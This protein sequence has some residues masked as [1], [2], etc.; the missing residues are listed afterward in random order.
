MADKPM[1]WVILLCLVALGGVAIPGPVRWCFVPACVVIAC[2]AAWDWRRTQREAGRIRQKLEAE[3]ANG[4][5]LRSRLEASESRFRTVLEFAP[6]A[7]LQ[8]DTD[9][10]IVY[11]NK[12][13]EELVG[14]GGEALLK[15]NLGRLK[16]GSL[17]STIRKALAGERASW[18]G[19]YRTTFS[20]K[21]IHVSM[22]C[23]PLYGPD[24]EGV[25]G[26]IG[27][28][29]DVT[30]ARLAEAENEKIR[31]R[32]DDLVRRIPVGVYVMRY[33]AD[34]KRSFEYVSPRLCEILGLDSES[35][36]RDSKVTFEQTHP[37]DLP[38]LMEANER[39]AA[40]LEPF[41][42]EGRILVDGA[43]RWMRIE[44][45]GEPCENGDSLWR[46]VIS[47]RTEQH[48]WEVA[49]GESEKRYGELFEKTPVPM[50]MFDK[51]T[52]RFSMVNQAAVEKYGYS[53]EEFLGMALPDLRYPEDEAQLRAAL[54]PSPEGGYRG[55]ARHRTKNGE[56]IKV[57]VSSR[58]AVFEGRL[59]R[60][61]VLRD[62]TG[63]IKAQEELARA[64]REV[65]AASRSKSDFL[66]TISHEIRTPM[67]A[68]MGLM[69]MAMNEEE[70]PVQRER[71]KKASGAAK[72]LLAILND[73]LDYSKL[74]AGQLGVEEIEFD[75]AEVVRGVA[76]LF[77]SEILANGVR[78][79]LD[80]APE[81]PGRLVGDPLRLRQILSN[82]VGNASKFTSRG[83]IRLE[84][85][86]EKD[87]GKE[88][89]VRFAVRDTGMG[90]AQERAE[91]LFRPFV[92]GDTSTTRRFGGT[93]LGLSISRALV[94]RMGGE[95]RVESREG[96]GSVFH[97]TIRFRAEGR[98][99]SVV[100]DS[101]PEGPASGSGA[102]R[103]ILLVED[104]PLNQEVGKGL[105]EYAGYTVTLA[106]NGQV[107]LDLLE[108]ESFDLVL[109][110]LHMPVM[111]GIEATR[112]LRYLPRGSNL[113]VI[114][115]TADQRPGVVEECRKAGMDDFVGKPFD[116]SALLEKLDALL[117]E[118]R[119]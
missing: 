75:P 62:V 117:Q 20:D 46:G 64:M 44:S 61:S 86:L 47:D 43:Q 115:L 102:C 59:M 37:D 95:L 81:I 83:M 30:A 73:V 50:W 27:I 13:L 17:D 94:E 35:L 5:V 8:Y 105:L 40:T 23:A 11:G 76:D 68:V 25:Q 98:T 66:A 24:G 80:F 19:P 16:D 7:I 29:V 78:F 110:D 58:E 107:A 36:L 31:R 111:G 92:Q 85:F 70:R 108:T 106:E 53:R 34:G 100:P 74:E 12:A 109:M 113:P 65:E 32:Y 55:M 103:R 45:V 22:S 112:K 91:E 90:I 48:E 77:E 63:Q 42:W 49:L 14:L 118:R 104:N 82:L 119:G 28:Y 69:Q 72:A 88:V 56:E 54:E 79:E 101:V 10:N 84:A 26:G 41:C 51:E 89:A 4:S 99:D 38:S 18:E 15:V 97:F 2:V 6:A 21:T 116:P 60:F 96:K 1:K 33:G 52:L 57:E 71:L 3:L 67:N 9:L 114:A 39:C 93:G 87:E